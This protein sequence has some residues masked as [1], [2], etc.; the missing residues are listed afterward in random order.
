MYDPSLYISIYKTKVRSNVVLD[1]RGSTVRVK[2]NKMF[3]LMKKKI[4]YIY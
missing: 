2:Y 1:N 4:I 3:V